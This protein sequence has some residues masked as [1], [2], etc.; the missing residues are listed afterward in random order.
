MG[1]TDDD[2]KFYAD[3]EPPEELEPEIT[4]NPYNTPEFWAY[5][6][7]CWNCGH[8]INSEKCELDQNPGNGYICNLCG[9]S[10]KGL[11]NK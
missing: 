11:K 6:N 5:R 8:E 10:L 3:M 2:M 7:N 1:I 9:E 4:T